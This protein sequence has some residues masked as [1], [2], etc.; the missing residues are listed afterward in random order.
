MTS[1]QSCN[2]QQWKYKRSTP[3]RSSLFDSVARYLMNDPVSASL[4]AFVAILQINRICLDDATSQSLAELFCLSFINRTSHKWRAD[5]AQKPRDDAELAY[6]ACRLHPVTL[7][8]FY[9]VFHIVSVT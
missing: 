5:A 3:G 2:E 1:N 6:T 4:L 8:G 9:N 7:L